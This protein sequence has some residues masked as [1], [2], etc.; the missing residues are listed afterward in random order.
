MDD[1]SIPAQLRCAASA[2]AETDPAATMLMTM[3]AD[4]ID[5]LS[6]PI[7]IR[8]NCPSCGKLHV[9][10]GEFATKPHHTHSCQDCGMTWRPGHRTDGRRPIPARFQERTG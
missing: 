1:R 9:D 8:L 7:P 5:K 10:D 6:Q 2:T 4:E 3:A